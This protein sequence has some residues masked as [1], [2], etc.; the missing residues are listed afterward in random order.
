MGHK[1]LLTTLHV[2][3]VLQFLMFSFVMKQRETIFRKIDPEEE[4]NGGNV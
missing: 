4:I 2:F 3:F 1:I